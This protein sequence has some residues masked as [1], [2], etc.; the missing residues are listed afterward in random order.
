MGGLE[1]GAPGYWKVHQRDHAERV[2]PRGLEESSIPLVNGCHSRMYH[3][4]GRQD[5]EYDELDTVKHS[6]SFQVR[7]SFLIKQGNGRPT[8][9]SHPP[10]PPA[11]IYQNYFSRATASSLTP[12]GG[13]LSPISLHTMNCSPS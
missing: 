7:W 9:S 2:W 10:T 13:V 12:G 1:H 6:P 5:V 8:C 11:V 4:G 3:T